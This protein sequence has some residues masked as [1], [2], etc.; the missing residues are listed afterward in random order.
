[1]HHPPAAAAMPHRVAVSRGQGSA[2]RMAGICFLALSQANRLL[3]TQA[4]SDDYVMSYGIT[5]FGQIHV[6]ANCFTIYP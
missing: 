6:P 2:S 5:E 3:R 4:Y 1:M